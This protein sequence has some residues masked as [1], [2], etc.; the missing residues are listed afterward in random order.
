MTT[1]LIPPGWR[2][3]RI[4]DIAEVTRGA[5]PRPIASDRWFDDSSEVGWVRISDIGRS[6]GLLL[7][8]TTQR[9]SADGVARS[10]Y[11]PPGTLIMSIAATVGLPIITGIPACIHDGF[12]ALQRLCGVDQRFLFYALKAQD[13]TLRAAGQTGSQANV[14]TEIVNRIEIPL[15]SETE[16]RRIAESLDDADQTIVRLKR[17]IAKKLS[18]KQG[19]MQQLLTGKSRLP[20]F[21][22]PW[23]QRP[24]A[25]LGST[26]GGLTGKTKDDFG[27]GNALYVPFMAVMSDVR[28]N[29]LSLIRVRI[30]PDEHQNVVKHNDLVFNTSSETLDELAMCAVA[31]DLPEPTYLNSFCFG[32]RL[33]DT[34][35]NDPLFIANLFRS[36][37]GRRLLL[38]LAQGATR[39]NLSRSQFLSLVVTMPSIEE[40][41]AIADV[42]ADADHEITTARARLAKANRLKLGMMQQLLTGCSR[43]TVEEAA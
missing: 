7:T 8:A 6:D 38:A 22:Q 42:L 20:G 25:S 5:S 21:T 31:V 11:L 16:Q 41:R 29:S 27:V 9:L 26:Y 40:Q 30:K 32:F 4:G 37:V 10:R 1:P 34:D 2:K 24:M 15:P 39:Y 17:L 14:N 18:I 19:L 3:V 33:T 28:I 43:I 13:T 35:V 36:D 12:V 23:L